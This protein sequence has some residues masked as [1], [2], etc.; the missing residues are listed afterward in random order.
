M[1]LRILWNHITQGQPRHTREPFGLMVNGYGPVADT[2]TLVAI[3]QGRTEA[4]P[5]LEAAGTEAPADIVGIEAIGD[6]GYKRP[7]INHDRSFALIARH[8]IFSRII[9][10]LL[11]SRILLFG[12]DSGCF[13]FK[14]NN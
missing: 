11:L 7:V 14:P 4:A 5:G 2:I 13:A 8:C 1:W 12:E 3:G 6:K 10:V 9:I